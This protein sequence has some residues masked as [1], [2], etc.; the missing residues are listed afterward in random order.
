MPDASKAADVV[1]VLYVTVEADVERLLKGAAKGVDKVEKELGQIDDATDELEQEFESLKRVIAKVA[2]DTNRS[3]AATAE[4]LKKAFA[5]K[6]V[7]LNVEQLGQAVSE[8]EKEAGGGLKKFNT[9]GLKIPAIMAG[10]TLAIGK[11]VDITV[12]LAKEGARVIAGI[13]KAMIAS[14]T[15]FETATTQFETL[16]G[17]TDLAIARLEYLAEFGVATPYE[18][19]EITQASR[20]LEVFGG[21]TLATG[22][23]LE[24]IG[25]I[26]AGVGIPFEQLST[27]VGRLYDAIQSGRPMGMMLR[28][29]Q[30]IGALTGNARAELEKMSEEGRSGAEMWQ[31]F[32][33]TVGGRFQGN[34][35]RLS[36]T[37]AGIISNIQDYADNMLRIGGGELFEEVREAAA[38]F[39]QLLEDKR[40]EIERIVTGIGDIFANIVDFISE[41]GLGAL[42]SMDFSAIGD[43]VETLWQLVEAG[44]TI[45]EALGAWNV[46]I[47]LLDKITAL[48]DRIQIMV[49]NILYFKAVLEGF[50]PMVK[51]MEAGFTANP[52]KM[53]EAMKQATDEGVWSQERFN[54][55]IEK[56]DQVLAGHTER[57]E[58][59]KGATKE[60]TE[61]QQERLKILQE[62]ASVNKK[63]AEA[64]AAFL[65]RQEELASKTVELGEQLADAAE[66]NDEELEALAESHTEKM[67]KINKKY[68]AEQ[69]KLTK[70]HFKKE[71]NLRAKADEQTAKLTIDTERRRIEMSKEFDRDRKRSKEDYLREMERMELDYQDGVADAVRNR[72]AGALVDLRRQHE[73]EQTERKSDFE[74]TQRRGQEDHDLALRE[75]QIAED[76]KR[77]EIEN[78]LQKQLLAEQLSYQERM[79]ALAAQVTQEQ[80]AEN[81]SFQKRQQSLDA[82]MQKRLQTIAKG[83]ADERTI[84]EQEAAN[85]LKSLN[86]TFGIGG[87]IDKLMEDFAARRRR[88]LTIKLDFE[89]ETVGATAYAGTYG[90]AD[91][92]GDFQHGGSVVA[93]RPTLARFGEGG[94]ELATFTPLS[95][96]AGMNNRPARQVVDVNLQ[97][98]GSAPPGINEADR[99]AIA[100]VLVS[101]IRDT[102]VLQ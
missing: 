6:G 65:R 12:R 52:L 24:M 60:E 37:L 82:A 18:L 73:R 11:V 9:E 39:L 16:L 13:G 90:S 4:S 3:F 62:A 96:L 44:R 79:T 59:H 19:P 5:T 75:L 46:D 48:N 32:S 21:A 64:E 86:Q 98:G 95:Q 49:K 97:V 94:P 70:E 87:D 58:K 41:K 27:T 71:V 102:G 35:D 15:D 53:L 25:D 40:P 8:L 22:E 33:D 80:A 17:S 99:D 78:S 50:E 76:R 68:I 66:Q 36:A 57:M 47:S 83:L 31:Y 28:R 84:D 89:R 100:Q 14:N 92:A 29:L 63:A 91:F 45:G 93:R 61:A 55:A 38:R 67:A 85:I 20:V 1:E 30:E 101:A 81:A 2:K 42:E 77:A 74:L 23:N 72:D 34:M 7:E 69:G 43:L 51:A 88:K 54:A 56:A 26:A 10:A